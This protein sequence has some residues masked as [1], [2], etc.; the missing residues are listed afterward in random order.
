MRGEA[1]RHGIDPAR[2]V[3]APPVPYA[4]YLARH[5]LADLFLD[6]VP[7]NAGATGIAALW[8]GLPLVTL[9]G[10]VFVARMAASMLHAIGLPELV[11]KT[12]ADYETWRSSSHARAR[13]AAALR[14]RLVQNR[15]TQPLFDID[16]F[17]RHIEAAYTTMWEIA[18]RGDSPQ[19]F[20]VQD[21][22]ISAAAIKP[23]SPSST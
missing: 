8:A 20:A 21:T 17:R 22:T 3:F 18:R 6:T 23:I 13:P 11:T 1:A 5:R 12:L 15:T 14:Q 9:Q 19:S 4:E 16:R 7:Y 10:E 2:L